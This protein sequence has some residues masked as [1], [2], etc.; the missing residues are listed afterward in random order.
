MLPKIVRPDAKG[1]VT[2]GHELTRGIS[3]YLVTET[4][5]HKLILEPQVEIPAHEKWLFENKIALKRVKRGLQDAAQGRLSKRGG[6]AKYADDD[7]E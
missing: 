7:I 2:L 1:R 5:D 4:E 3:G 6:F